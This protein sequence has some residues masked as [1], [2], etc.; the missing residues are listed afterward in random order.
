MDANYGFDNRV[1][2][3]C[4]D[5]VGKDLVSTPNFYGHRDCV[6]I[7]K[8]SMQVQGATQ[9]ASFGDTV[10]ALRFNSGKP[11]CSYI[12]H[13]PKTIELLA[14]ILE[15][16][17]VKYERLNWKKGGNTDESYLDAAVRHLLKFVD[18]E[19]FDK[20]YGTCHLGHAIWNLMTMF[21]L[22]DHEIMDTDKF[23]KA[24]EALKDV[25]C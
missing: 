19:N 11:M 20:E 17:E 1:C 7:K 25:R 16:G 15:V 2:M 18:G 10:R 12:L 8:E 9:V 5:P 14:R 3:T 13:Y 4:G 24:L 6:P 23:N 21:E 22:N